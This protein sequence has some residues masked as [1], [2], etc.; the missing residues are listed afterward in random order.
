MF[1]SGDP[2][3]LHPGVPLGY[4]GGERGSGFY[5]SGV[6]YSFRSD[7][8]YRLPLTD[9]IDERQERP[10]KDD[11]VVFHTY[12]GYLRLIQIATVLSVDRQIV[13]ATV[14]ETINIEDYLNEI[15]G[16][17]IK[18]NTLP[19]DR[20]VAGSVTGDRIADGAIS[21]SKVAAGAITGEKLASGAVSSDKLADG[22]VTNA[23]IASGAVSMG[24]IADG[25]VTSNKVAN[26]AIT[27]DKI[28]SGAVTNAKVANGAISTGKLAS[29]AVTADK[30][31]SGAITSD[32]I[33]TG[34]VSSDKLTSGAVT[35]D[36][37]S[38]GA[39]TSD[40]IAS[41]AVTG[42]KISSTII[43][44]KLQE[45]MQSDVDQVIRE[46]IE[47]GE[48]VIDPSVQ[49][50]ITESDLISDENFVKYVTGESS[51]GGGKVVRSS[52]VK[53]LTGDALAKIATGGQ[54]SRFPMSMLPIIPI[55]RADYEALP[56]SI[57]NN[58]Y[59][60]AIHEGE[61]T[62]EPTDQWEDFPTD[63]E[64]TDYI[65]GGEG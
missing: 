13:M 27:S 23:K 33:A 47:S 56:S 35:A 58:G 43:E 15:D 4:I 32:K 19:G 18:K 11:T 40:K 54:S 22:A 20:I 34:A 28:A 61:A 59:L 31:S 29:G 3:L 52:N 1:H 65:F 51:T 14:I 60:Y 55:S 46:M 21:S 37:V 45:V 12:D 64:V 41:G 8:L 9:F 10:R 30:V 53:S 42:D 48:I 6:E 24:K 44:E 16:S 2:S 57:K 7:G 39:I 5:Y 63:Q 25:A 26:D 38:S 49:P 17:K 36:K 50:G 62:T